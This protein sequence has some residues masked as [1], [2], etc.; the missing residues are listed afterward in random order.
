MR[1]Y[2][3]T[4]SSNARRAVMTALHLNIPVELVTVDLMNPDDRARLQRIN[5][6]AKIPVLE[7]GDLMLWESCAIMQHLAEQAPGQTVYPVDVR[8]RADVNRWLFWCV[9]HF[10]P[11]IGIVVWEN[12]VKGMTGAGGPDAYEVARGELQIA[13]FARVLDDHLAQR[14]W[15]SGDA[16]TLADLAIAAPL[17][18]AVPAGLPVQQYENV[19]TWFARVQQLDCWKQTAMNA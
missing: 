12:L 5:P 9:Q 13:R 15:I 14:A 3:N 17:M 16:L 1:L 7:D 10:S 4:Y 18:A 11:A 2:H 8:R 19:Q 6:N